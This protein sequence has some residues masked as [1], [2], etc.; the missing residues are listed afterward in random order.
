MM[1]LKR[2]AYTEGQLKTKAASALGADSMQRGRITRDAKSGR[3]GQMESNSFSSTGMP[4]TTVGQLPIEID[5]DPLL[6]DIVF[7]ENLEQKKLVTRLYRDMYYNDPVCGSAAD[8]YSVLPFSDFSLGGISD[9]KAQQVFMEA[10]ERLNTRTLMPAVALDHLVT[11]QFIGSLLYNEQTK[12]F[13]DIMPH[14]ADNAKIDELPFYGQDPII[15]VA[16]PDSV[17]ALMQNTESTRAQMMR[18]MLGPSVVEKLSNPSL[19]LDPLST[20]YIP[21]RT[22]STGTGV[23]W[24]RRVLPIYLIEKN[25]FRGTLVESARRQRGILHLSLGEGDDWIPT[26]EDMNFMTDLF[27]N[28]D[29]D[30]LGAIITTRTGV[31]ADEVRQGGDFW[32]VTDI[33]DSTSQFKMRAMG[34]SE[35]F[36]SGDANYAN[37]DNSMSVFIDSMRAYRDDITRK[38]FY[39]RLFPTISLVNGFAVNARGKL[40]RRDDLMS[41]DQAKNLQTLNDGSKLLIPTVHWAKQLKPEGDST[42]MDMLATLTEKG[43]PIPL[44]AF[45]AAGGFNLDMLLSGQAEELAVA[46][47]VFEYQK[48]YKELQAKFGLGAAEGGEGDGGMPSLSSSRSSVLSAMNR[49]NPVGLLNRDYGEQSEVYQ[50]D[51]VGKKRMI[52]DQKSANERANKKIMKALKEITTRKKTPLSHTSFTSHLVR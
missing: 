1:T 19:E 6:K 18:D 40:I 45:A 52:V 27:R 21:R 32:K 24:F 39:N 7:S 9:P 12:T 23:S 25:L 11:G 41:D 30:P 34:I 14:A 28:A 43:V 36:L 4:N 31:Q 50:F 16:I 37:A 46:Q 47:R 13:A 35:S 29:A 5:I 44:R 49:R 8:L 2:R 26:V 10:C 20:I 51:K 33:W 42:Y 38:F 15:T 22:F 17:K 3:Y 48:K